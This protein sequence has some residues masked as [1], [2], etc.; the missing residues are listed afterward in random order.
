M[1]L[2]RKAWK[3][4]DAEA[5]Y[6]EEADV[7]EEEPR[8]VISGLVKYIPEEEMQNRR[9]IFVC[10]LKPA[11]MRGIKSQAMVLAATSPDGNSV[12]MFVRWTSI[13]L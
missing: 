11:N 4:P 10:N 1:G 13:C 12:R 9:V 2:I 5:L 3:H 7:G 6:V 8:T